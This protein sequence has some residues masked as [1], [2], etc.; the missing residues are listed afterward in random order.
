M[1]KTV[2]FGSGIG[3]HWSATGP[4]SRCSSEWR[5]KNAEEGN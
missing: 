1:V 2:K 3:K 4:D 5:C